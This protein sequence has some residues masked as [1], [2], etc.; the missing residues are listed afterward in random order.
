MEFQRLEAPR[1]S[2]CTLGPN[3]PARPGRQTLRGRCDAAAV[4]RG[5]G[6]GPLGAAHLAH[7]GQALPCQARAGLGA[8]G[9][10]G[11]RTRGSGRGASGSGGGSGSTRVGRAGPSGP[12]THRS[13]RPATS[14]S[15]AEGDSKGKDTRDRR[16]STY[17]NGRGRGLRTRVKRNPKELRTL[18]NGKEKIKS[19]ETP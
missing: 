8:G 9:R 17:R 11:E 12:Y 16:H 19:W 5:S 4:L 3:P 1:L 18:G 6:A 10:R 14:W 15:F 2:P 13:R 7:G